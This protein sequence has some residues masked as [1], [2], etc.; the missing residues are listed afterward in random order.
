MP[1]MEFYTHKENAVDKVRENQN[2]RTLC[3][4]FF[5]QAINKYNL[6]ESVAEVKKNLK[7]F[8]NSSEHVFSLSF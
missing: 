4:F 5:Y 1:Y 6:S 8:K 2:Q 7:I 3:E